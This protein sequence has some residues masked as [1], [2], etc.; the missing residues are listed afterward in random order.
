MFFFFTQSHSRAEAMGIGTLDLLVIPW[1]SE[2]TQD[3]R[4]SPNRGE[5]RRDGELF[6]KTWQALMTLVD[7][8]TV[9]SLGSSDLS[10]PGSKRKK[11]RVDKGKKK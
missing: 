1:P 2:T 4:G 8:S 3:H 10:F 9:C 7:A 5:R 6:L 11:R